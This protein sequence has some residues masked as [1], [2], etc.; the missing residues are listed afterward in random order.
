M[1]NHADLIGA[2]AQTNN[3]VSP[4]PNDAR[5]HTAF[6]GRYTQHT[7]MQQIQATTVPRHG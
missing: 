3:T 6:T 4:A 7:P 5:D 2:Y 1:W